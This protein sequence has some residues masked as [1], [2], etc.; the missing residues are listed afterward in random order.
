MAHESLLEKRWMLEILATESTSEPSHAN[1]F[2]KATTTFEKSTVAFEK[3]VNATTCLTG[4]GSGKVHLLLPSSAAV[5]ADHSWPVALFRGVVDTAWNQWA[6][7]RSQ[8]VAMYFPVSIEC[9]CQSQTL[10]LA[11]FLH[12]MGSEKSNR[13]SPPYSPELKGSLRNLFP[14]A[15]NQLLSAI[16]YLLFAIC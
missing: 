1:T 10:P 9:I 13:V 14:L 15:V 7:L 3:A 11:V 5:Q 4:T 12:L 6:C 2:V 16:Y 8:M